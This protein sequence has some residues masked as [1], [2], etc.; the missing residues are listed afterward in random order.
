MRA[1]L[2][3][4]HR[5]LIQEVAKV[6]LK[7]AEYSGQ[8]GQMLMQRRVILH[9]LPLHHQQSSRHR[10]KNSRRRL[11]QLL[12]KRYNPLQIHSHPLSARLCFTTLGEVVVD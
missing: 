9:P 12:H 5:L 7:L 8:T 6:V 2:C 4:L 3:P 10:L 1:W 11:L